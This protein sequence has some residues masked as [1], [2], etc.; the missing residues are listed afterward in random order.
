MVRI[1]QLCF[2]HHNGRSCILANWDAISLRRIKAA[3]D[4]QAGCKRGGMVKISHTKPVS[5]VVPIAPLVLVILVTNIIGPMLHLIRI[6]VHIR[7][8]NIEEGGADIWN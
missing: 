8:M 7:A 4:C 6:R 5:L 2:A 1:G 3:C